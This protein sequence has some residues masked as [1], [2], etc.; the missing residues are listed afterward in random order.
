MKLGVAWIPAL[1]LGSSVTLG[2]PSRR[3]L[4]PPILLTCTFPTQLPALHTPYRH[5]QLKS[6]FLQLQN[7]DKM[8]K[9]DSGGIWGYPSRDRSTQ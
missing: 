6:Q 8:P 4:V 7:E 1:P 9:S 5:Y 2:K 3:D